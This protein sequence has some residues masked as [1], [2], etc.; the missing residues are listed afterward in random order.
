M[1]K[2]PHACRHN[3]LSISQQ[4][5]WL[6]RSIETLQ[7]IVTFSPTVRVTDSMELIPLSPMSI[8]FVIV[9]HSLLAPHFKSWIFPNKSR[10]STYVCIDIFDSVLLKLMRQNID[11]A[12]QL[13]SKN[14]LVRS[15][16]CSIG[17]GSNHTVGPTL[18]VT[19]RA[20]LAISHRATRWKHS[21]HICM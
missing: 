6:L 14:L 21:M 5:F 18:R 1:C 7:A 8:C 15:I 17:R 20:L 13:C 9:P 10:Y 19:D 3:A 12:K 4:L 11:G 16:D 2:F